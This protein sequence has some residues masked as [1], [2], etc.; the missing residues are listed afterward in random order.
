[1]YADVMFELMMGKRQETVGIF[2]FEDY[3]GRSYGGVTEFV[4]ISLVLLVNA[5]TRVG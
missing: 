2:I 5:K 1:M 3:G 4:G